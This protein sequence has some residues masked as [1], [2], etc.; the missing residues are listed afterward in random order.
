MDR[1]GVER[2]PEAGSPGT[3]TVELLSGAAGVAGMPAGLA[4]PGK[5]PGAVMAAIVVGVARPAIFRLAGEIAKRHV[6]DG[7]IG[8][9]F[10]KHELSL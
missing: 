1:T 9:E 3:G 10:G 8:S 4:G 2:P 7:V 6:G 5:A